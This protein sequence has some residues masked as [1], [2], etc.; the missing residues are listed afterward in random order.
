[1]FVAEYDGGTAATVTRISVAPGGG[2]LIQNSYFPVYAKQADVIAF[3]EDDWQTLLGVADDGFAEQ[4]IAYGDFGG[5]GGGDDIT[6]SD[7]AAG[8]DF[9]G[10]D[11]SASGDGDGDGASNLLEF[12]FGT[13]PTDPSDLPQLVPVIIEDGGSDYG[14]VE[15]IQLDNTT[16]ATVTIEASSEPDFPDSLTVVEVLPV[17]DLG[18]GRVKRRFRVETVLSGKDEV[19]FRA[20]AAEQ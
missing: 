8:F 20:V 15:F 11:T 1:V 9:G 5:G 18:N 2:D 14:G 6:Y 16:G 3:V 17:E 10:A 19:L 12:I 7:W 13:D 4:L